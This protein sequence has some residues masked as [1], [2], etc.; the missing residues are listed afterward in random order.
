MDGDNQTVNIVRYNT[1]KKLAQLNKVVQFL[2]Y[3]LE[4]RMFQIDFLRSSAERQQQRIFDDLRAKTSELYGGIDNGKVDLEKSLKDLYVQRVDDMRTEI[5]KKEDSVTGKVSDKMKEIQAEIAKGK[6]EIQ[7]IM[8]N[9]ETQFAFLNDK[10]KCDV[11]SI[12]IR[13]IQMKKDHQVALKQFDFDAKKKLKQGDEDSRKKL[14]ELEA[15]YQAQLERMKTDTR[16]DPSMK[17]GLVKA[18]AP[19][20]KKNAELRERMKE[21]VKEVNQQKAVFQQNMAGFRNRL[22]LFIGNATKA[23]TAGEA[24]V[25]KAKE[26]MEAQF[27]KFEKEKKGMQDSLMNLRQQHENEIM[28]MKNQMK[29]ARGN[30]KSELEKKKRS[31]S[32][33]QNA[34]SGELSAF[35]EQLKKEMEMAKAEHDLAQK[36][37]QD[38]LARL[39]KELAS[40]DG[41]EVEKMEQSKAKL[42]EDNDHEIDQYNSDCRRQIERENNEFE[43]KRSKLESDLKTNGSIAADFAKNLEE[44]KRLMETLESSKRA[45]ESSMKLLDAQTETQL[46]DQQRDLEEVVDQLK[47]ANNAEYDAKSEEAQK[48]IAELQKTQDEEH[49]RRAKELQEQYNTDIESINSSYQDESELE[50]MRTEY[51]ASVK[52][53]E[54]KLGEI[55]VPECAIG[56]D[57]ASIEEL[58]QKK[59]ELPGKVTQEREQIISKWEKE[60]NDED[61]RHRECMQS[62]VYEQKEDE[63]PALQSRRKELAQELDNEITALSTNLKNLQLI[64]PLCHYANDP[65]DAEQERLKQEIDRLRDERKQRVKQALAFSEQTRNEFQAKIDEAAKAAEDA[66]NV[67][68]DREQAEDVEMHNKFEELRQQRK[69]ASAQAADRNQRLQQFFDEKFDASEREF[70]KSMENKKQAIVHAQ[71]QLDTDEKQLAFQAEQAR[72]KLE[73]EMMKLEGV[74]TEQLEQLKANPAKVSADIEKMLEEAQKRLAEAQAAYE[75]RPMREE[76]Y[77]VIERLENNLQLQTNHLATV[78]KDLIQYRQHLIQQEEEY[79]GRFGADPAVAVMRVKPPCRRPISTFQPKRLPKLYSVS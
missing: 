12:N 39:E 37:Y 32:N 59:A 1:S 56:I 55:V 57:T 71:I 8:E 9:L 72:L 49:E 26:D 38:L 20:K 64:A 40:I 31:I 36:R 66:L 76:E 65:V 51:E 34:N 27:A 69:D 50:R 4:E 52:D 61:T 16:P 74:L 67:E 35:E 43:E 54:T 2:S 22:A 3:H 21:L 10:T 53:L 24:K 7:K 41:S 18:L 23:R 62:F 75:N 29:V 6:A 11:S 30:L 46:R 17:E 70:G 68:K 60:A 25:K 13:I 42:F 73:G 47:Q 63:I 33:A 58:R 48:S 44:K 28:A 79:N 19:Q 45:Y 77:S 14:K 5:K 15:D 78:G